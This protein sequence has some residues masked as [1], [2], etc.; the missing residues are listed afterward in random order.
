MELKEA[1]SSNKQHLTPFYH[2]NN[3]FIKLGNLYAS[4]HYHCGGR[5][6][7]L[8]HLYHLSVCNTLDT[9]LVFR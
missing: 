7:T 2:L 6:F 1:K 4:P 9:K 3:N 8:V 5:T